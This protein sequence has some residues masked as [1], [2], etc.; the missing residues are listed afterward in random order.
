MV[1]DILKDKE[2]KNQR[3]LYKDAVRKEDWKQAHNLLLDR[4]RRILKAHDKMKAAY[5]RQIETYEKLVA[6]YEQQIG[7]YE[8]MDKAYQKLVVNLK[9]QIEEMERG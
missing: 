9:R 8:K 3:S 4:T 1:D 7:N 2:S 6:R 5:K